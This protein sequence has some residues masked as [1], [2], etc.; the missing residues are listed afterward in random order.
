MF[1]FLKGFDFFEKKPFKEIILEM[2]LV[3]GSVVMTDPIKYKKFK[4]L[5][6]RRVMGEELRKATKEDYEQAYADFMLYVAKP[7]KSDF[8]S[9]SIKNKTVEISSRKI[10]KIKPYIK[11]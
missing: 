5:V 3:D 4:S 9:V 7:Y 6:D 8:F 11:D 10:L 1:K 2:Y